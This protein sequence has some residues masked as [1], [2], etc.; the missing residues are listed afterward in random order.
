MDRVNSA[1]LCRDSTTDI[2]T[3]AIQ[4]IADENKV[5]I[6]RI[7]WLGKPSEKAYGSVVTFLAEHKDT[8]SLLA[9]GVMDF[10]ARWPS[11]WCVMV[12]P[13]GS[14]E[15][16]PKARVIHVSIAPN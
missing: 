13:N 9:T 14:V 10:G 15:Y 1:S 11:W 8:E 7:H 12:A 2:I 5:E 16:L 6:R 3:E 4:A